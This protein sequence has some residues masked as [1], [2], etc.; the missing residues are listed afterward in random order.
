[1]MTS[2]YP[3]STGVQSFNDILPSSANT[4]AEAFREGRPGHVSR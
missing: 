1:M 2:L 3:T 4:L